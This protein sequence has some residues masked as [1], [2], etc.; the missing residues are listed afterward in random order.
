VKDFQAVIFDMDGLLLD[1]E[2]IARDTFV[3]ACKTYDFDPDLNIY[4]ECIG[5]TG[6]GTEN[7]LMNGYGKDFPYDLI[8]SVWSELYNKETLTKPV[9][10]KEG[11]VQLLEL[12]KTLKFPLSV[13]TSSRS[14]SAVKKLT[15]AGL[16]SYFSSILGGDQVSAGKPSPEIYIKTSER[17][18]IPPSS[19]LVIEDSDNGVRAAHA[20]G[21]Q[22]IQIP[23][24]KRPSA[25]VE[26]FGHL[27]LNSLL[28]VFPLL[29]NSTIH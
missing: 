8:K 18:G 25:E 29:E 21:M 28:D 11:V 13:A 9:P 22:V 3:S 16:I 5:T 15:N 1:S 10:V 27:I 19:C 7:V 14:T 6:A 26:N 12:L 20:A 2:R 24:L 4:Y 17:I 23:D